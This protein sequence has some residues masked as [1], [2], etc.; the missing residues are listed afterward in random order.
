[1][2]QGGGWELG[3]PWGGLV[4]ETVQL[5]RG[6]GL[7]AHQA[8]GASRAPHSG[9]PGP[10]CILSSWRPE[11]CRTR[12]AGVTQGRPMLVGPPPELAPPAG[13]GGPGRGLFPAAPASLLPQRKLWPCPATLPPAP[14]TLAPHPP[15]APHPSVGSMCPETRGLRSSPPGACP[16]AGP[17]C[18]CSAAYSACASRPGPGTWCS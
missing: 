17:P 14:G 18:L 1:M 11:A 9:T 12:G 16:W 4:L 8:P 10:C 13:R 15:A 7:G 3:D 6:Q 2:R 5:G